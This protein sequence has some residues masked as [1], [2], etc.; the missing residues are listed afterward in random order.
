MH[1]LPD[2][3]GSFHID[4]VGAGPS[5]PILI[6][7]E[8]SPLVATPEDRLVMEEVSWVSALGLHSEVEAESA[9]R[10]LQLSAAALEGESCGSQ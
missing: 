8:P 6:T 3:A 2:F 10:L 4:F 1:F 5:S 9:H 7:G